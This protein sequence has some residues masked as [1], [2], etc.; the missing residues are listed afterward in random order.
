MLAGVSLT[1]VGWR[2][3]G[4]AHGHGGVPR[5]NSRRGSSFQPPR[6]RFVVLDYIWPP[7]RTE[8]NL[9]DSVT[10]MASDKRARLFALNQCHLD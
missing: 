10:D 1:V 9:R 6:C 3:G 4:G 5:R 2:E 8:D 7:L